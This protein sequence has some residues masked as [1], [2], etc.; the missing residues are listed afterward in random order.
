MIQLPRNIQIKQAKCLKNKREKKSL[1]T[2]LVVT[3]LLNKIILKIK[4]QVLIITAGTTRGKMLMMIQ[5]TPTGTTSRRRSRR[6]CLRTP[7][8][9]SS[10]MK[11]STHIKISL[12]AL[13]VLLLV[14]RQEQILVQIHQRWKITTTLNPQKEL[15]DLYIIKFYCTV[16]IQNFLN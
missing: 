5:W 9:C 10:P 13:A 11:T 7:T 1:A 6:T 15:A 3:L 14:N 16:K 2:N 8:T 4:E 12:K